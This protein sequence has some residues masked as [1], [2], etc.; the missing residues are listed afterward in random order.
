MTHENLVYLLLLS[1]R[2]CGHKLSGAL[3][4]S[5]SLRFCDVEELLFERGI[6]VSLRFAWNRGGSLRATDKIRPRFEQR[7]QQAAQFGLLDKMSYM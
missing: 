1:L 3:A 2:A 7:Q 4:L 5:L 6:A